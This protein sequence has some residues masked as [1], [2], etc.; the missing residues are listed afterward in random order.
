MQEPC[1][2][3]VVGICMCVLI[4]MILHHAG[5]VLSMQEACY[6]QV[7]YKEVKNVFI[8]LFSFLRQQK[9][10]LIIFECWQQW[11]FLQFANLCKKLPMVEMCSAKGPVKHQF[12]NQLI[13]MCNAIFNQYSFFFSL[14]YMLQWI[15]RVL[16][17]K[18]R[19]I[20]ECAGGGFFFSFCEV[21]KTSKPFVVERAQ[22]TVKAGRF[23][24]SSVH[25]L[26]LLED[27]Q[28]V[29]QCSG[30]FRWSLRNGLKCPKSSA[31]SSCPFLLCLVSWEWVENISV[32]AGENK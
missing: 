10:C 26:F 5:T 27:Q 4:D 30:P 31:G 32:T 23:P 22:I 19:Y 12:T 16:K 17:E 7:S 21:P 15:L 8:C 6:H 25:C 18:Y 3:A 2:S 20:V 1:P 13:S 14:Q 24:D 29:L 9:S 11:V 28:R